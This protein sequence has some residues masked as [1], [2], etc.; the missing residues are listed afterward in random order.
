MFNRN[1]EIYIY[2]GS[3]QGM[4][5]CVFK[6][7]EEKTIPAEI[8][9]EKDF[10]PSLIPVTYV[11][12]D[13]KKA[14]RVYKSLSKKLSKQIQKFIWKVYLTYLP[15]KIIT[16]IF[17]LELAYMEGPNVVNMLGNEYVNKLLKAVQHM[18]YEQHKF[19]GF[20][21][22][23]IHNNTLVS[24]IE[25]NNSILPLIAHHFC[26]RYNGE[27]FLIYDKTHSIGLIYSDYKAEIIQIDNLELPKADDEELMYRNLWKQF[28]DTIAIKERFNPKC[29]MTLMPKRYWGN[30]TEFNQK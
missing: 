6:C 18:S 2:D 3:F 29:R 12:T 16:T 10:T 17:F 4:L 27:S 25:P 7:F 26:N 19:L 28:Y 24:I 11:D 9:S 5:T 1:Q 20:I 14:E 13:E 23:S 8:V 15:D 21:R 30:M 22:F